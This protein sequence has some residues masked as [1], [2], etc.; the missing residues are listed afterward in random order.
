MAS[1]N[2]KRI[3]SLSYCDLYNTPIVALDKLFEHILIK[4][5]ATILEPC[6]GKGVIADYLKGRGYGIWANEL[7]DHGYKAH[8]ND[9]FL[10]WP[11]DRVKFD[12]IITNPPYKLAKEFILKG[13]DVAQEQYHLLRLSFLESQGRYDELF[14]LGHL[15]N[16]YTF[17]KR[18]SCTEGV[19]EKATAN[20][21]PYCWL[22]FDKN[23]KGKPTLHWI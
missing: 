15:K 17:V 4:D 21:V 13:F 3:K 9:D 23:Y 1:P 14:S 16:I 20:S 2:T 22:H 10:E 5:C 11:E 8:W 19:D 12:Y 6:A 18:I 7:F